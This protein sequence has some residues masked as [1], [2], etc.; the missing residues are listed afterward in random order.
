MCPGLM[1]W[2]APHIPAAEYGVRNFA[3]FTPPTDYWSVGKTYYIIN[4]AGDDVTDH[5]QSQMSP[6]RYHPPTPSNQEAFIYT[7]MLQ[8]HP[9][10]FVNTRFG[11]KG[12]LAVL[13]AKNQQYWDIL[14]RYVPANNGVS[15]HAELC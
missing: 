5:F 9:N 7:L 8:F 12:T 4:P 3:I 10:P 6:H 14:I 2:K 11:P 15:L 1:S 13:R